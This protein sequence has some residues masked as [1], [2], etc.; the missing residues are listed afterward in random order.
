MPYYFTYIKYDKEVRRMI[1]TTNSIENLNK[2]IRKSTK[3]KLSF[4]KY[5]RLLDYVF[6]VIKDFEQK[7]SNY[8]D[9]LDWLMDVGVYQLP[10]PAGEQEED[11]GNGTTAPAAAHTSA[12]ATTAIPVAPQQ[13]TMSAIKLAQVNSSALSVLDNDVF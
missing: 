10:A 9:A 1:Y 8:V 7:T 5:D 11:W 2:Q 12:A 6:M 13:S 4:E 3:N